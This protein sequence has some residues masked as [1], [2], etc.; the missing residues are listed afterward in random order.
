MS[1]N[2][3]HFDWY[4][5]FGW[6]GH[7]I[8]FE[9]VDFDRVF[10]GVERTY[11]PLFVGKQDEKCKNAIKNFFEKKFFLKKFSKKVKNY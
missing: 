10:V 1:A 9:K 6:F 3:Q 8:L 11:V 5:G 2:A 7:Q 4:I